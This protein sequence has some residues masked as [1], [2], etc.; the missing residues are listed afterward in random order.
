MLH[1]GDR[2]SD[3]PDATYMHVDLPSDW[4][5]YLVQVGRKPRQNY[6]RALRALEAQ[7]EVRIATESEPASVAR[8][9]EQMIQNHDR[10]AKGT[11]REQEQWFG[12]APVRR[13][14]V[15]A[16]RLL[17]SHGR[18]L[19]FTLHLDDVP[20][21]WITGVTDGNRYYAMMTSYD[22]TYGSA[23]PG[24]VLFMEKMHLLIERK[25]R[26]VELTTGTG[27]YKRALG[28]NPVKYSRVWGYPRLPKWVLQ[29][30]RAR[31]FLRF[32]GLRG[33]RRQTAGP[34]AEES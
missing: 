12:D 15:E 21:A 11:P 25:Y 24:F 29:F 32:K 2:Y 13:Y 28:G 31:S 16:A 1:Y 27:Y 6:G 23:S 10:W 26:Y 22:E 34:P 19:T 20:V 30:E 14:Y 7:G 4:E 17:A 33:T 3:E 9:V 18:Y 5:T 8:R